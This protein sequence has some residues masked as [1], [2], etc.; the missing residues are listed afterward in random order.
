MDPLNNKPIISKVLYH[1]RLEW[2]LCPCCGHTRDN[3]GKLCTHCSRNHE[4][5]YEK[6]NTKRGRAFR[7]KRRLDRI[8]RNLCPYC[9]LPKE[10]SKC[11]CSIC[12]NKRLDRYRLDPKL[13]EKHKKYKATSKR[14]KT[15][16][17]TNLPSLP[18]YQERLMWPLS[19]NKM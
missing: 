10:P 7:Q 3:E 1:E 9:G 4:K 6:W 13:R 2:G 11:M 17:L 14:G 18:P 19:P 8:K 16:N 12:R 5:A 15:R